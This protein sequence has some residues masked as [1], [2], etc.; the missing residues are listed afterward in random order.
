MFLASKSKTAPHT[1]MPLML[2]RLAMRS[3]LTLPAA[4]RWNA[5]MSL[6]ILALDFK[7]SPMAW[8]G[9]V[10]PLSS[11]RMPLSWS[12]SSRCASIAAWPVDASMRRMPAATAPSLSIRNGPMEPVAGTWMP[13]HNSFDEP[14]SIMRTVSPY[15]SPNSI[16]APAAWASAMAMSLC[17]V[18]AKLARMRCCTKR[19]ILVSSSSVT[20]WKCEKSKRRPSGLTNDPFCST[21]VPST[22]R[23]ASWS[24]CVALWFRALE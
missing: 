19:S 6:A 13:P 7:R 15:F 3:P 14:N 2:L 23:S 16:M 22:S 9:S 17:S 4:S 1:L 21:C 11:A 18:Q 10:L 8:V 12:R 5:S 20:F 24:K